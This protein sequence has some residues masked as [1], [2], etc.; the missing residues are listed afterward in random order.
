MYKLKDN[1]GQGTFEGLEFSTIE[2]VRQH[3]FNFHSNDIACTG[4]ESLDWFLD[5]GDWEL[6]K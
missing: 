2:G 5:I 1:Q 3:L 6:I 4:D